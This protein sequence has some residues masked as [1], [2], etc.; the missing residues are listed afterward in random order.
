M[1]PLP[2]FE[3]SFWTI[4]IFPELPRYGLYAMTPTPF[5]STV[6]PETETPLEDS[7]EIPTSF[8]TMVLFETTSPS[9]LDLPTRIPM[10]GAPEESETWLWVT[11]KSLDWSIEI[12]TC[13]LA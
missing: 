4:A 1:T 9:P 12:P 5:P 2:L 7:I 10:P 11:W 6:L 13:L 8:R 3:I